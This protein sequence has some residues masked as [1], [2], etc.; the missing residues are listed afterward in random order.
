[1]TDANMLYV[2]ELSEQKIRNFNHVTLC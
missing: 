1:V 2:V